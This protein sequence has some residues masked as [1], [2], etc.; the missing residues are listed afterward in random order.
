MAHFAEI[1]EN[2]VVLRVLVV[3]DIHENDGENYLANVVG[4]GGRWL[5]TSYNTVGNQHQAGGSPFRGN[6]AGTG[7]IYNPEKDVF[8]LP[9]PFPSWTLNEET[10]IWEAP[11]PMPTDRLILGWNEETL[12]WETGEQ[13]GNESL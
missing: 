8:Y 3:D 2:N 13:I 12:T 9:Q 1:D 10:Y 5:K 4:L 11:V 6:F 7:Y